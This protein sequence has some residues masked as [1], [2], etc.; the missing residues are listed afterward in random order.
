[1]IATLQPQPGRAFLYQNA[2]WSMIPMVM[3]RNTSSKGWTNP[4]YGM[5]NAIEIVSFDQELAISVKAIDFPWFSFANIG[6]G[7]SGLGHLCFDI[8]AGI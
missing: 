1:M 6:C 8:A 2:V 7:I 3:A 5:Y 4:I